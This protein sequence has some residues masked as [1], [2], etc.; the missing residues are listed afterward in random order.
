MRTADEI[1]RLIESNHRL[2]RAIEEREERESAER[3]GCAIGN[4][5]PEPIVSI[6]KLFTL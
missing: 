3:L 1:E 2:A 4:A 6:I 5:I